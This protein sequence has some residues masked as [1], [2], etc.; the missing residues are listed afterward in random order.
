ML[1]QDVIVTQPLK[2]RYD[3]NYND[4]SRLKTI[5]FDVTNDVI[6]F[7][8][9]PELCGYHV[10]N[11]TLRRRKTHNLADGY[12]LYYD[13]WSDEFMK[14]EYNESTHTYRFTLTWDSKDNPEL[15]GYN[16]ETMYLRWKLPKGFKV[17]D[18][19]DRL[20]GYVFSSTA[21][22][23]E[24]ECNDDAAHMNLNIIKGYVTSRVQS[25]VKYE[26]KKDEMGYESE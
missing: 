15:P 13:H 22:N 19:I 20:G 1:N 23:V 24:F 5:S 8:H 16:F 12:E 14:M 18:T 26:R 10:Q 3:W 4:N 11:S 7:D 2:I 21:Q 17:M 9:T 6:D 25:R